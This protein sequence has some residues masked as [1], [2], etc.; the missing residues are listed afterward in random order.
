MAKLFAST[1]CFNQDNSLY[2]MSQIRILLAF[3]GICIHFK[4]T[5]VTLENPVKRE[6][7]KSNIAYFQPTIGNQTNNQKI[8]LE[9]LFTSKNLIVKSNKFPHPDIHKDI[10]DGIRQID[11]ILADSRRQS[12]IKRSRFWFWLLPS[13]CDHAREKE[14]RQNLVTGRYYYLNKLLYD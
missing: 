4:S 9:N 12:S 7:K 2:I 14:M 6:I 5:Y 10:A 13:G 8:W 11:H 3:W 1:D